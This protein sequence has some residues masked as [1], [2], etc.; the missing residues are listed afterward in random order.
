MLEK[1]GGSSAPI[2]VSVRDGG[3]SGSPFTVGT[4]TNGWHRWGMQ[5]L[6]PTSGFSALYAYMD[7]VRKIAAFDP[8][9][10]A[11]MAELTPTFIV[12]NIGAGA[13]TLDIDSILVVQ[14]R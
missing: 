7:G 6:A 11:T 12:R 10:Y 4:P 1:T 14:L 13:R 8:V 9:T 2:K 5:W 3:S